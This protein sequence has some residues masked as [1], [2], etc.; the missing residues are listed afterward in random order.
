MSSKGGI[1]KM[2]ENAHQ[3]FQRDQRSET[4]HGFLARGCYETS[5]Q[6]ER[7]NQILEH[8]SWIL[9]I[10]SAALL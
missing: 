9:P 1:D 2:V 10:E 8:E 6:Y 3:S 4:R 5:F 7:L